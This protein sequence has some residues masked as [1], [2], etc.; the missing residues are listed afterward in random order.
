MHMYVYTYTKSTHRQMIYFYTQTHTQ[1]YIYTNVHSIYTDALRSPRGLCG[2][3]A[4]F[5]FAHF[6]WI[7]DFRQ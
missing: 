3:G 4:D 7:S 6:V 2:L 1:T 5:R